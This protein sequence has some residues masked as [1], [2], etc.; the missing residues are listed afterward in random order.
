MV[1][2]GSL[3]NILGAKAQQSLSADM[4]VLEYGEAFINFQTA[5]VN[6]V[7]SNP[8]GKTSQNWSSLGWTWYQDLHH[9]HPT[10]K[11]IPV[12][13]CT[14]LNILFEHAELRKQSQK[15]LQGWSSALCSGHS[16]HLTCIGQSPDQLGN[17]A[18]LLSNGHIDT[19]QLL[20][21]KPRV[22]NK[23]KAHEKEN[24]ALCIA[25]SSISMI[26][27]AKGYELL[28]NSSEKIK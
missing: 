10:D 6:F 28:Q 24:E 11:Q 13:A 3:P 14:L 22:L 26:I 18:P 19:V 15:A 5:E 21:W 12:V 4:P 25:Q 8:D 7:E 23:K 17:C 16:A 20:L 27:C 1:F 9:V 2:L